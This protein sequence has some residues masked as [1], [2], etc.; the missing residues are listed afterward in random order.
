MMALFMHTMMVD[1]NEED[2]MHAGVCPQEWLTVCQ[3]LYRAAWHW[4]ADHPDVAPAEI[5]R[6]LTAAC[7]YL[8][9]RL[10]YD[11]TRQHACGDAVPDGAKADA[12]A[13]IRPAPA[14]WRCQGVD[15]LVWVRRRAD[16][17][18]E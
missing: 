5:E 15:H 6:I 11:L 8:R 13:L 2:A 1:T 3:D 9:V 10:T 16:P 17:P 14:V 12:P 4:V 7:A 18:R